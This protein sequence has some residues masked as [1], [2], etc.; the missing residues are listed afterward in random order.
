MLSG[1][2]GSNAYGIQISNSSGTLVQGNKIGL[3]VSGTV[4]IQNDAGGII[5]L[6]G[7][8]NTIGGTAIGSRNVISGNGGAGMIILSDMTQVKGNFFGTNASGTAARGNGASGILIN[9]GDNN[10]IGGTT[11]ADRNVIAGNGNGGVWIAFSADNNTVQGNS[12]GIDVTGTTAL[13]NGNGFA[14]VLIESSSNNRIGGTA[15]GAGNLIAFSQGPGI[16]VT[17]ASTGN[18]LSGNSIF[19]NSG[20]GIDLGVDGRTANDACDADTGANNKQNFPVLTAAPSDAT[21]TTITG[22]LNATANTLYRIEVFASNS[23][24]PSGNGEGKVF[25]GS[26]NVST[27]G[28]CNGSF[29]LMVPNA[30]I[31]GSVVTATATDPNGNTSEFSSCIPLGVPAT[32]LVQFSSPTFNV[33]EACTSVSLTVN[34]SG[35]TSGAA[36]VNTRQRTLLPLNAGI[37]SPPSVLSLSLQAS[38]QKISSCSL[39]TTLR[40]KGPRH[41]PSP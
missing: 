30:S 25:L 2:T 35:D 29:M 17:T 13:G 7:S 3:D 32:N 39:T 23:C 24:D 28:T 8:N 4:K 21:N 38:H 19:S 16:G 33:T 36:T 27:D 40:S 31:T 34:R 18:A 41:S 1:N 20:L 15:L 10:T 26:T 14:N 12:I 6:G 37:T 5:I 11:N 9:G 22:T